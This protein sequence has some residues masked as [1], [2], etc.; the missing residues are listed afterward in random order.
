[1]P[2]FLNQKTKKQENEKDNTKS[3]PELKQPIMKAVSPNVRY[4]APPRVHQ[5]KVVVG[6][7][8]ATQQSRPLPKKTL[9][10]KQ[11]S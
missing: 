7:Q 6:D 5:P 4:N 11:A 2:V 8:T 9:L 10:M 1:M 3:L